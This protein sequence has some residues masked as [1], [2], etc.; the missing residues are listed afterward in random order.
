M[1]Q[2][3]VETLRRW[4]TE[5]RL[6]M[7]R[8]GG[9]QRLVPIAE[10]TRLLAEK[11]ASGVERPIVS[12][13]ARNRFPGI[14]TRIEKDRVAAVVEVIAGPHR[15]VSLMTA[16]AVDEMNLQVGDEAVCVVKATN[17]IVEVPTRQGRAIVNRLRS[18]VLAAALVAVFGGCSAGGASPIPS[19]T[20]TPVPAA[21][22]PAELVVYGAASLKGLLEAAKS[23][24]EA[25][26]GDITIVLSTDSSAALATKIEEGAPADLFLSADTANPQHLVDEGLAAGEMISFA[27]NELA[28]IVPVD[29]PAGIESPRDLA[30]DG[31]R[32]IA[33]GDEVPITTYASQLIAQ[34]AALPGYPDD[35]ADAYATNVLSKEENVKAVVAKIALGEGDAGIVYATDAA[36]G[37]DVETVP[38]P[39]NSNVFAT[40]AAIVINGSPRAAEAHAF[41]DWLT[42]PEGLA[43]LQ[44]LGF[45]PPPE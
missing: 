1:L 43:I 38:I 21:T 11:R 34:L 7:A 3:S 14:V 42:G 5:G 28:I 13:S 15:M 36:A 45:Q 26:I 2:V 23:A 33:A 32:I 40:Y 30:A 25:T 41:L 4:E 31:V 8:S 16:E 39:P 10:V 6:R 12:G 18:A 35:F 20:S 27:G 24:Y 44:G 9:G 37:T 19:A 22:Q 17:V 29:N